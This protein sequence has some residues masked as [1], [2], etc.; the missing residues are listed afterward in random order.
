MKIED[1][2]VGIETKTIVEDSSLNL[3]DLRLI[4]STLKDEV[5]CLELDQVEKMDNVIEMLGLDKDRAVYYRK[6]RSLLSPENQQNATQ[7]KQFKK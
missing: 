7:L 6:S 3:D 1:I 2:P 5:K 4:W